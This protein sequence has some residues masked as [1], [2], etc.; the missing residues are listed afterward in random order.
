[1]PPYF[2]KRLCFPEPVTPW[3]VERLRAAVLRGPHELNGA[4]AVEDEHGRL[5][6]LANMPRSRVEGLAKSLLTNNAEARP[7][8]AGAG[9]KAGAAPPPRVR[10]NKIVY[11]HLQDGDLMLTNRQPT[12]HKPGL[13]AHRARVLKGEKTIRMHYANCST[14]NADF[15]GDEINLHLPQDQLGRAEGYTIVHADQ[16]F[17]V[18]TDGKPI[19]GL[20]Q[21]HVVAGVLLC[22]RDTWLTREQY[23]QLVYLACAEWRPRNGA[24]SGG[25]G[26]GSDAPPLELPAMIQPALRW[27]GKQ[28][29][30]SVLAYYTAGL[31]PLT[32]DVNGKVPAD[33][34][35]RTGEHFMQFHQ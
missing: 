31:P 14:F 25:I 27:A 7:A 19:R 23:M 17:I 35:G 29:V 10:P 15:D 13:M 33:Y 3:N 21:D 9:G 28:V 1:M 20:I 5:V 8:K 18:P 24:G 16:Q 2:A 34:W 30:S 4:V 11:R 22:S 26:A 32:F 6:G 12:L